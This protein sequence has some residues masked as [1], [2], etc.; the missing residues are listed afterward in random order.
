MVKQVQKDVYIPTVVSVSNL[1]R[2]LDMRQKRMM[3]LM[4][5]WG[6]EE[7]KPDLLV[8]SSEDA[9]LVAVELGFNPVIDDEA[10][11]DIYPDAPP[12]EPSTLPHRPPV[13]TIMGHVDHGKTTLLDTLRSTSVAKG[14]AGGI[15][16]HI[17]AFSV[18]VGTASE[19]S[20]IRTIT[21]L[22]TPG[23]AAFTAMRARGARVTDIIVCVVA[24]DDGVM[25]QTREVLNLAKT[26]ENVEL[27]IAINKV[28]KPQANVE[29]VK[30][31]LLAEGVQLESLGGDV[32]SVEVSGLTGKGLDDLI[33]TIST[34]AE[35]ADLRA[36]QTSKAE[37]YVLE[38]KVDK[39]RGPIAT[40]LV[41]SGTL[42]PGAAIVAG[43]VWCRVRQMMDD[44]GQFV[45]KASPGMPVTVS[46]W[47]ELP[48]A[49]DEVLQAIKGE[50]D[51]KRAVANRKREIEKRK[52]LKDVEKINEVRKAERI[53]REEAAL[54]EQMGVTR[55]AHEGKQEQGQ[56]EL[57]L[58][59]KGDVSG[60]VEAVVGSVSGIGNDEVTTKVVSSG[61]G[62][63]LESDVS[64][65]EASNAMV[66][67]FNVKCQRSVQ[68]QAGKLGVPLYF[69]DVIYRVM[70]E[71]RKRASALL[72]PRIEKHVKGELQVAEIFHISLKGRK[73]HDVAGCKVT[74]GV[75][76]KSSRVRVMRNGEEVWEGMV[77]DLKHMK[78]NITEAKKGME[79]GISLEGFEEV[80]VG[81][82]IQAIDVKEIAR[83]V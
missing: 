69:D 79:C 19:N 52:I 20:A 7:V 81:D 60:T 67:G 70:E 72:P 80:L 83:Q 61:V 25:P 2:I 58:V 47:K 46:G 59:I 71:V 65:A 23:H 68:Q 9:S 56:K 40:V 24:A 31:A 15:T 14:E 10:A 22:D 36:D 18:P 27:V 63:V 41:T 17:G 48:E 38:S 73:T 75:L 66:I 74:N 77:A 6:M 4:K 32:P 30:N 76:E 64:M 11:F 12:A 21:F 57:R 8:L 33:E 3:Q 42:Q 78:K 55:E 1:A 51:A 53:E 39:G 82:V 5:N 49:G 62:E 26:E 35:V 37:G 54:A 44:K 28:D 43:T 45:K 16:Q 13:V 29:K 34:I 50:D